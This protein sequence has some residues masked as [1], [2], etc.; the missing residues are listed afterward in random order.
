MECSVLTAIDSPT[1]RRGSKLS[2]VGLTVIYIY[3]AIYMSINMI[4]QILTKDHIKY[5]FKD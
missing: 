5:A 2:T 1:P 4:D 3:I